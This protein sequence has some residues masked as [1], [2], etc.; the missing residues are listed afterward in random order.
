MK[1]EKMNIIIVGDTQ[2]GK[3]SILKMHHAKQFSHQSISTIGVDFINIVYKPKPGDDGTQKPDVAVKV[4]DTA[5]QERFR[6]LTYQMYKQ[7]DGIIMVFAKNNKDTYVGVRQWIQSIYQNCPQENTPIILAGNKC[8][9]PDAIVTYEQGQTM[10]EGYKIEY[11]ET[12]AK[13]DKNIKDLFEKICEMTYEK[14]F[15]SK[16]QEPTLVQQQPQDSQPT[17]KLGQP[18]PQPTQKGGGCKC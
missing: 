5:G 15:L 1:K 4:W 2:V 8:D 6:S 16:P 14:K 17:V 3:T 13:E 12:S 18:K 10:A 11:I 7:A 9:I